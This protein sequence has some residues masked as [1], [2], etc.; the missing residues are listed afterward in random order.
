VVANTDLYA[1]QRSDL[2][3]FLFADVGIEA[4]GMTLSVLSALSRLGVDP[5]Q[6]AARLAQLPRQAAVEAMARLI[7]AMPAKMWSAAEARSIAA[8]LVALLP[9]RGAGEAVRGVARAARPVAS[10]TKWQWMIVAVLLMG[11]A[12][13]LVVNRT[14]QQAAAPGDGTHVGGWSASSAA[15]GAAY[16]PSNK[17][18]ER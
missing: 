13:G 10:V 3:G 6:E 9:A 4:S 5:W 1:L 18:V 16:K 12:I 8:R 14:G 7:E 11:V 17:A 15:A 2:N